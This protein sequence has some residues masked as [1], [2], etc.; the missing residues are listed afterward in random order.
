MIQNHSIFI[1]RPLAYA[2]VILLSC[3]LAQAVHG[4]EAKPASGNAKPAASAASGADKAWQDL[5]QNSQPPN[6][7]P[8]WQSQRPPEA[9]IQK[10]K[11]REAER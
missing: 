6:P 10:F 2:G 3:V 7:P 9:E 8:E 5:M 1:D 4:Q 11:T